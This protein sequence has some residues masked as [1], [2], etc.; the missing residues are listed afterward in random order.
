MPGRLLSED[1]S[2]VIVGYITGDPE[3]GIFPEKC[4]DVAQPFKISSAVVSK[5]WKRYCQD[6][7]VLPKPN[8][9]GKSRHL[10]VT[11]NILSS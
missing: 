7:V 4:A 11:C 5:I 6:K 9:G 1:L 10:M 3:T 2:L 8:T